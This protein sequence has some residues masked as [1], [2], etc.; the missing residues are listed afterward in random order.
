MTHDLVL[1]GGGLA[2]GLIAYRL[3]ERRPDLRVVVLEGGTSLGGNHTWSFHDGD[4]SPAEH[5]WIEPFVAHRW[6]TYEVRFPKRKRAVATG[7]ASVSSERFRALLTERLGDRLVLGARIAALTP[8]R[9][10]LEDG[11]VFAGR[12]VIDG[13]GHRASR[14]LRLGFQK[15]LGQEWELAEPHGLAHPIVMDATVPQRDGYRFVYVLPFSPTRLLIEDT[16]YADGEALDTESLRRSIADYAASAGWR[17]ATLMREEHGILPIALDGRIEGLVEEAAG[18]PTV[19]LARAL[20]HPTTGY[21][22]PDAVHVADLVAALPDLGSPSLARLLS[23]HARNLWQDRAYFRL[24]NRLLFLAGRP[25]ERY[26]ILEHFYRLP[27]PLVARFY[28]ARLDVRDKIRIFAGK[29]PI[30]IRSAIRVLAARRTL[31]D[32]E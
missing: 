32:E 23:A 8:D 5:A 12:A 13:R 26:R 17:L 7:Y 18:V 29:P 27:D 14:H 19:G 15:F 20:F 22:L 9:V 10:T 25:E 4:L 30:S 16:Y 24:L 31:K 11:R 28:A 2:N 6:P 1:A 21:S 3:A